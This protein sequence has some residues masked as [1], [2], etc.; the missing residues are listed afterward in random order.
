MID[1]SC[2]YE[3]IQTEM[4]HF[5][6]FLSF[7]FPFC[8]NGKFLLLLTVLRNLDNKRGILKVML[9]GTI[10]NDDFLAQRSITTLLRHSFEWLQHCSDIA[11]LCCA[12][13]RRC[14]SCRHLKQ[15]PETHSF[16]Q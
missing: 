5:P 2:K 11:T 1:V 10:R 7:F 9:H 6:F 8:G 13:N 3:L 12:Q 15:V 4:I 14:E 16:L